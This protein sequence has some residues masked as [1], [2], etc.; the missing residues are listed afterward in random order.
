MSEI[1]K[2]ALPIS[3]LFSPSHILPTPHAVIH[4]KR[5]LCLT[6]PFAM[7]P[8]RYQQVQIRLLYEI[9]DKAAISLTFDI[10]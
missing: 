4:D 9:K 3:F 1:A 5:I 8:P 10:H 2:Y 7:Q 6:P